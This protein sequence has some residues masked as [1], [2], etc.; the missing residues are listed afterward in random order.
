MPPPPPSL[1]AHHGQEYRGGCPMGQSRAPGAPSVGPQMVLEESGQIQQ[2]RAQYEWQ[3]QSKDQ[4]IRDLQNRLSREETERSQLQGDFERDR[5]GLMRHLNN[6]MAAVERYGVP[7]DDLRE[8]DGRPLSDAAHV[9][10]YTKNRLDSK[11]E[12]LNTLL[13]GREEPPAASRN[14]KAPN[15]QRAGGAVGGAQT[16]EAASGGERIDARPDVARSALAGSGPSAASRHRVSFPNDVVQ[17]SATTWDEVEKLTRALERRTGNMIDLQAKQALESLGPDGVREALKR[18]EDLVQGQGGRCTNLSSVL[19]SVCRKIRR[20]GFGDAVPPGPPP[21]PPPVGGK[22]GGQPASGDSRGLAATSGSDAGRR[23]GGG[24]SAASARSS[25]DEECRGGG[26]GRG[27]QGAGTVGAGVAGSRAQDNSD[28]RGSEDD[29]RLDP[30]L[31]K[32]AAV[33]ITKS[34]ERDAPVRPN[35]WSTVRFEKLSRQG[36]FELKRDG[37]GSWDLRINMSELDPPLTDEG[38]QVYCRWLHQGLQRVREESGLRSLRQIRAEVNFSKNGLSDEAVGRL[39]QALQRSE[40]SVTSLNLFA[41]CI[42]PVGAHQVCE[43]LRGASFALHEVHLS[44]NKLDDEAALEMIRLFTDHPKYPPRKAREGGVGEAPVPVWLRLNNNW[45]KD[46]AKVLKTVEAEPGVSLSLAQSRNTGGPTLCGWLH[47]YRFDVQDQP[48]QNPEQQED[49]TGSS[50]KKDRPGGQVV[51]LEGD[52]SNS[53][54]DGDGS[55]RPSTEA[56]GRRGGQASVRRLGAASTGASGSSSVAVSAVVGRSAVGAVGSGGAAAGS[57]RPGASGAVTVASA[58]SAAG[59]SATTP[60]MPPPASSSAEAVVPAAALGRSS[61]SSGTSRGSSPGSAAPAIPLA[62]SLG[63]APSGAPPPPPVA[64]LIASRQ[65]AHVGDSSAASP[66]PSSRIESTPSR[67]T[68]VVATRPPPPPASPSPGTNTS[69]NTS[70]PGSAVAALASPARGA[71]EQTPEPDGHL[72]A[73]HQRAKGVLGTKVTAFKVKEELNEE[74]DGSEEVLAA[75]ASS[76]NIAPPS[77][78]SVRP[79]VRLMG[80]PKILQRGS[81]PVGSA[82]VDAPTPPEASS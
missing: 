54:L 15:Q 81:P 67:A 52:G 58:S 49:K 75:G 13:Q 38:M 37:D 80:P 72:A 71:P 17:P 19:Q 33:A 1:P 74:D 56:L 48:C 68:P 40:L 10:M 23:L 70:S 35:P 44:H 12:Q 27:R 8:D 2:L 43:F 66:S 63:A 21:P 5:Q 31:D 60:P 53:G 77:P 79:A 6:L 3:I 73:G 78:P 36:A 59:A 14:V 20:H 57:R 22:Q 16:A 42:G 18:A 41:N 32:R 45:I 30:R 47:M 11:M 69:G 25:L 24:S 46:P 50:R 9:A 34:A 51:R 61:P 76:A 26:R 7:V 82:V 64:P 55:E 4:K 28:P 65:N 39:L 29:L 62:H